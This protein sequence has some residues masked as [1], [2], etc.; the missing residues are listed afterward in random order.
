MKQTFTEKLQRDWV[1]SYLLRDKI[2][3]DPSCVLYLPFYKYGG[4]QQKI[5]DISGNNNHGTIYGAAPGTLGWSFDGVDDKI[6]VIDSTSLRLTSQGTVLLWTRSNFSN[7]GFE[8]LLTKG[9]WD[10]NNYTVYHS[11][12]NMCYDIGW[13]GS[14]TT[15]TAAVIPLPSIPKDQWIL[16][17][18]S[19]TTGDTVLG[20]LNGVFVSQS[21]TVASS[22]DTTGKDFIVGMGDGG[23]QIYKGNIGEVLIFNR[24]LS[25]IEVRNYYELTR[26]RYGV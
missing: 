22:P 8:I 20:Y 11:P 13:G 14:G 1:P 7:A 12:T 19:W 5:W 10:T 23:G 26:C 17:S 15:Y 24:A 9:I 6:T 2:D 4:E 16:L 18:F 21:G 25:A 3:L